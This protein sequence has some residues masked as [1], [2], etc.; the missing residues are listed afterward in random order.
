MK[1]ENLPA[2]DLS[3]LYRGIDDPQIAADLESY[4]NFCAAFADR[5]RGKLS[6]LD[7]GA[8]AAALKSYEQNS[9]IGSKIGGFAVLCGGN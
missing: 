3:D 5:Y 6:A 1:N 2:W 4:K 9:L 7:G 8:F